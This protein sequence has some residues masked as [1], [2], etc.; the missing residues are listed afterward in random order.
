MP[1][2]VTGIV[3]TLPSSVFGTAPRANDAAPDGCATVGC[4]FDL[5]HP[6]ATRA[7][8]AV[9]AH[10]QSL[11]L[12]GI[13]SSSS[14]D[15]RETNRGGPAAAKPRVSDRGTRVRDAEVVRQGVHYHDERQQRGED[16]PEQWY[17]GQNSR[18]HHVVAR[19]PVLTRH[20]GR[21][22]G[23]KAA[24]KEHREDVRRLRLPNEL[25]DRKDDL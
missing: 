7:R 18:R 20:S 24:E 9:M 2:T 11:A 13:S 10:N 1:L 8:A 19:T 22:E 14:L 23:R 5:V 25:S 6:A 15:T 21:V 12:L 3:S 4:S 16:Q 17:P